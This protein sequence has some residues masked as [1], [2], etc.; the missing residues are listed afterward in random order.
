MQQWQG[1]ETFGTNKINEVD[2]TWLISM[3]C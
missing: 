1:F 3:E 2:I